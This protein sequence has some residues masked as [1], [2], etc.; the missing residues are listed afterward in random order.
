MSFAKLGGLSPCQCCRWLDRI[1]DVDLAISVLTVREVRKGI[2]RL[3]ATK[4]KVA[5][6]IETRV[7]ESLFAF[8]ERVLPINREIADLWGE[9]LGRSDKNV[10]D[11]GLAATARVHGLVLVTRNIRHV[12]ARGAATL[13]P[14]RTSPKISSP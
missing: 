4:P 2:A 12:A 6:D 7:T 11:T 5:D 8:G 9:L 13:D 10:D 3:R 14:F 1:D